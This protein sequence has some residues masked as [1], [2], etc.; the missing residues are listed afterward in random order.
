MDS[1]SSTTA[2]K[3]DT[4]ACLLASTVG[5]TRA[6]W[7]LTTL[8]I[9]PQL[10]GTSNRPGRAQ[11]AMALNA[12]LFLDL[13]DRVP[14]AARYVENERKAGAPIVFD[15][16]ALRTIDGPC[17]DLPSGHGAFAR[18]LEPMGYEVG[19]LYPLPALRMTGRAFVHRD[20]PE[21]IPQFFVSE[22]HIAQLPDT[23][24]AAAGRIF[25]TSRDPLDAAVRNA[26]DGLARD[27]DCT[28]REAETIVKGALKAFERQHAIPALD[29]YRT[30]LDASKEG[31]WIA[32][33]GNAFNHATTRVPDVVTLADALKAEG[34]P[35][36][37]AVE[38]SQNGRVRQT[39]ILADKVQR[40]FRL[41]DGSETMMEVP[42]SFYEFITRD[43]D[44][45]SGMLDLTF[46]SGNA[47]GIFA[48][49]RD[50]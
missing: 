22:L 6:D 44:P 23:A 27:G 12:A 48:V 14:T 35:M 41:P 7:A 39:A 42:G 30:L 36:K 34:Y 17:G 18:F 45:A 24:Q 9:A 37:P 29:D 3:H 38:I 8:A 26:L 1:T 32:T 40:P 15:H 46:D 50:K 10:R 25:G 20:F 33:E 5:E 4:L 47:T 13:V 11:V 21:A 49:T 2:D 19:G 16:G 31:G 28:M 43:I